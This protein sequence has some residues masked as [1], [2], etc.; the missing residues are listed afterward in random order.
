MAEKIKR[1]RESVQGEINE[2]VKMA[3]MDERTRERLVTGRK[4]L[5]AI[6][7]VAA[8]GS[9]RRM[10]REFMR[11]QQGASECGMLDRIKKIPGLLME[12]NLKKVKG[13]GGRCKLE[14]IA[15]EFQPMMLLVN[16]IGSQD[17]EEDDKWVDELVSD[18]IMNDKYYVIV[19]GEKEGIGSSARWDALAER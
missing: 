9:K 11:E 16:K 13:N 19:K 14:S 3:E 6:R 18:Q 4:Q 15:R 2:L 8:P 17:N 10:T 1:A 7:Q 12:V 5:K